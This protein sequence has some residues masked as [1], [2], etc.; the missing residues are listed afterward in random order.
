MSLKY[1]EVYSNYRNKGY[2]K[3]E[4]IKQ[5]RILEIDEKEHLESLNKKSRFD[6]YYSQINIYM[7]VGALIISIVAMLKKS[8]FT[9][10]MIIWCCLL[11][12]LTLHIIRQVNKYKKLF[13][14]TEFDYDIL[15][16]IR[17]TIRAMKDL[18]LDE[19]NIIM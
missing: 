19:Y 2:T 14:T 8:W 13:E 12:L 1:N 16:D 11:I 4:M 10:A 3:N 7:C 18:L 17:I 9:T 5:I 15:R 6:S